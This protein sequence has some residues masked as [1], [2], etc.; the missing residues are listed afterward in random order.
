MT[1]IDW[2]REVNNIMKRL[3]SAVLS[4]AMIL[5]A[6]AAC[7][8]TAGAG[9]PQ[10][11]AAQAA[12]EAETEPQETRL[13]TGV[14]EG[15]DGNGYV[16]RVLECGS[17][18]TNYTDCWTEAET[19]DV[20]N[21]LIYRRNSA[22]QE[23]MNITI[24]SIL[25]GDYNA[26][27][28]ALS[29]SITAGEDAYDMFLNHMVTSAGQ[30]ASG[31]F[32]PLNELEYYDQEQP[33]WDSAVPGGFSIGHKLYLTNGD[34]GFNAMLRTSCMTF[35]KN[36]FDDR[37]LEYPYQSVY[38]GIWTMDMLDSYIRDQNAD[39]DGDMTMDPYK[40]FY[41]L[42]SWYLDSPYSFFYGA[43][44]MIILKD[45]DDMPYINLDMEKINNI[46]GKMYQVFI[47]DESNFCTKIDDYSNAY[48][49]FTQGRALFVECSLTHLRGDRFRNMEQDFGIIPIPKIDEI[50]DE[51]KSFLNG[52][53]AMIGVPK[54]VSDPSTISAVMTE[55]SAE[56][57]YSMTPQIYDIVV[58][59]KNVRD[60]QSADMADLVI[61]NHIYD[62]AYANMGNFTTYSVFYRDALTSK[63]TDISSILAKAEAREQK[64]LDKLI[65]KYLESAD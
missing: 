13:P 37:G 29:K 5:T 32:L 50:Q 14:P 62:M 61:R 12:D 21:D 49:M 36:L 38:D 59:T 54:T 58:K 8:E 10:Q 55:M 53:I 56:T 24:K 9:A 52:S 4:A 28:N 7:G 25:G 1:D 48:D 42:T 22:V 27:G 11:T 16:F 19:G 44:C 18:T 40:D 30:A 60:D 43:G 3:L 33:W 46:Y 6:L 23:K 39:L 51:Y 47:T 15:F 65:D 35:N 63:K 45:A 64:Q 57:Y 17:E 20:L 2:N 41:G 34:L 26:V 31:L